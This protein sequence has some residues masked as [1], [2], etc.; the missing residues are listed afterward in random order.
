MRS[1]ILLLGA[2]GLA[3]LLWLFARALYRL[4]RAGAERFVA[5][6][7]EETRAKRGDLTGMAEAR[8]WRSRARRRQWGAVVRVLGWGVLLIGPSFTH[9]AAVIYAA[10]APLWLLHAWRRRG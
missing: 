3:A 10:C 2:L 1:L 9:R 4:L 5:G 6:D 8:Q 7:A